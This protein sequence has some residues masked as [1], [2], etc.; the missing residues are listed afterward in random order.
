MSSDRKAAFYAR[1]MHT[2]DTPERAELRAAL[3]DTSKQL[4]TLHRHLI[5][6]AKDDFAFATGA[7]PAPTELLRLLTDDPFF[8]WLKPMTALIVEIDEMA[9]VDF[10]PEG[11]RDIGRRLQAMFGATEGD[12]ATHY[13]PILQREVDVTI[14]HAALRGVMGRLKQPE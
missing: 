7:M 8:G 4:M 1:R 14:A 11:A 5:N 13:V 2:P 10:E 6:A 12:F 3:R 9:R